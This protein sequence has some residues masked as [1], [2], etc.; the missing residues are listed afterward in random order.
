MKQRLTVQEFYQLLELAEAIIDYGRMIEE[1]GRM[2]GVYCEHSPLF[3]IVEIPDLAL[4]FR[5]TPRAIK[6]ALLLLGDLG[7]AEPIN[8]R[9]CW[10]LELAGTLLNGC[11][12]G[13]SATRDPHAGEDDNRNDRGAA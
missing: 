2:S 11:E 9:G 10:R 12:V 8:L 6:D 5:E 4:R 3:V 13:R 7:R 1:Y